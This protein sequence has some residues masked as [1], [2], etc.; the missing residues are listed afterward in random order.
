MPTESRSHTRHITDIILFAP[1]YII[2]NNIPITVHIIVEQRSKALH[3]PWQNNI[4]LSDK[5]VQVR[6]MYAIGIQVSPES[7]YSQHY[8]T[9][10]VFRII[11][12]KINKT[13]QTDITNI[14]RTIRKTDTPD[15]N[16]RFA[17][18]KDISL[19]TCLISYTQRINQIF[20]VVNQHGAI[21]TFS[22][23]AGQI[24]HNPNSTSI[25]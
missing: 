14:I 19:F 23:Q 17:I 12:E 21:F 4:R 7:R 22:C 24:I 8:A 5:L 10:S 3:H 18:I 13:F 9:A 20:P 6:I 2:E 16:Q 1:S 15:S 25:F 11:F